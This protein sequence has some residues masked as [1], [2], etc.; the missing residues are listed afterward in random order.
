V[1]AYSHGIGGKL[2]F[3]PRESRSVD[4]EKGERAAA[5]C[6]RKRDPAADAAGGPV[7]TAVRPRS[8]SKT[9]RF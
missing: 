3:S 4:I 1:G 6:E 8:F 9:A 2:G 7:T 5:A